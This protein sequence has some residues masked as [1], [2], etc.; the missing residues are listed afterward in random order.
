MVETGRGPADEVSPG[1]DDDFPAVCRS[2]RLDPDAGSAGGGSA[3]R[4]AV[5]R[6]N[7]VPKGGKGGP[8][9]IAGCAIPGYL[10]S[11]SS[12]SAPSPCVASTRSRRWCGTT[13]TSCATRRFSFTPPVTAAAML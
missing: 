1:P 5:T 4:V 2:S 6:R 11:S 13:S 8:T 9:D 7:S 12:P 10:P 3:I